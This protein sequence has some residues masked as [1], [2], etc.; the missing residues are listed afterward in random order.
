MNIMGL[1]NGRCFV[2]PMET[3]S[4]S[5][6]GLQD[7]LQGRD[8]QNVTLTRSEAN[9][10]VLPGMIEDTSFISSR[11]D[12]FCTEGYQ[13]MVLETAGKRLLLKRSY[14]VQLLA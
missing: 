9:F 10:R 6:Q 4:N 1:P 13:W 2:M 11:A 12:E 3:S 7:F 8:G 5:S 14:C